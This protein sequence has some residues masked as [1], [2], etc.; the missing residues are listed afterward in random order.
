MTAKTNSAFN[1]TA[2]LTQD[3]LKKCKGA[4]SANL[5]CSAAK[6][7]RSEQPAQKILAWLETTDFYTAPAST[8]Y[9]GVRK[10]GLLLHHLAVKFYAH[11]LRHT[12]KFNGLE[13]AADAAATFVALV[14]DFCKIGVYHKKEDGQGWF[15]RND[16]G[17]A[18]HGAKSVALIEQVIDRKLPEPIAEAIIYHM[19][20][21]DKDYGPN[22]TTAARKNPL[23]LLLHMADLMAAC[24]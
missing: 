13:Y 11:E 9:H 23:I 20:P 1:V 5:Y 16:S 12:A 19:G 4:Y 2:E 15:Y 7:F 24:D 10:G 8:K 3:G 18:G 21:V 6:V 14:H 22:F 17:I